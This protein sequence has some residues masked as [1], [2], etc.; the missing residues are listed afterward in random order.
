MDFYRGECWP[1]FPRLDIA[2]VDA[3]MR[4]LGRY[5][6]RIRRSAIITSSL[7]DATLKPTFGSNKSA[8]TCDREKLY[9]LSL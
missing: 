2:V 4:L 5:I 8:N 9:M 1:H 6:I 7:L 3:A